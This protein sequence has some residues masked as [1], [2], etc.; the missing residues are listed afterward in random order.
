MRRLYQTLLLPVYRFW[1]LRYIRRKRTFRY[2]PLQLNIPPTVFHPGIFFSTPIFLDYLNELH[3]HEK[4]VLDVGTGSGALALFAASRK[5]RAAA[6][7]INPLAVET[8]RDN[9][10]TNGLELSVW[11]S[12]L[13][14]AVP[15]QHFDYILINPPYYPRNPQIPEEQAFFAGENLE[16]FDKLFQQLPQYLAPEGQVLLILSEDCDLPRIDAKARAAGFRA[17]TVRTAFKW[18]ERFDIWQLTH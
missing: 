16:Y 9:A 13:F 5:A 2:G 4:R 3:L 7:D 12:N 10:R 17:A 8:A 11:E 6:L 1:A 18:G 14:D 15:E